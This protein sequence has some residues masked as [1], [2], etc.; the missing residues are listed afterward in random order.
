MVLALDQVTTS[1]PVEISE[2][3]LRTCTDAEE[4]P[5]PLPCLLIRV[6]AVRDLFCL[7]QWAV[8]GWSWTSMPGGQPSLPMS[9]RDMR[10]EN[11]VSLYFQ[12]NALGRTIAEAAW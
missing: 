8:D 5:R 10:V 12:S 9:R 7:F 3:L 1:I 2:D 11:A 6:C 4:P